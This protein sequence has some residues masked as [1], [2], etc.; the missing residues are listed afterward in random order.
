MPMDKYSSLHLLIFRMTMIEDLLDHVSLQGPDPFDDEDSDDDFIMMDW[1]TV[2]DTVGPFKWDEPAPGAAGPS[3]PVSLGSIP[4]SPFRVEVQ[5]PKEH[6]GP[7]DK[8]AE[9]KEALINASPRK[10]GATTTVNAP[11]IEAEGSASPQKNT[12]PPSPPAKSDVA[13]AEQPSQINPV[14]AIEENISSIID[15][16]DLDLSLGVQK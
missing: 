11:Q 2:E 15:N 14:A 7:V 3:A 16:L 8:E 9:Q 12:V 4:I 10:D 5:P 13:A 6:S 1:S